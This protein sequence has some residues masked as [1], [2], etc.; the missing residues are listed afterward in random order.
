MVDIGFTKFIIVSKQIKQLQS[1]LNV[2][3]EKKSDK[4]IVFNIDMKLS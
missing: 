4:L 3:T 1:K 2:C